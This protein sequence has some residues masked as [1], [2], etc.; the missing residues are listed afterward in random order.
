MCC[1]AM[2]VSTL[3]TVV[4]PATLADVDTVATTVTAAFANDPA[5]SFIVGPGNDAARGAFARALLIPRI[6]RGTAW[7][8]DDGAAVAMWDRRPTEGSVDEDDD[9]WWGA[10]RAEVGEDVWARLNA[11]DGA[12]EAVPPTPP[13]W[14]LG[15]LATHPEVQG[16]GLATAVVRPGLAAADAE[17]WDCWLETSTPANKAFYAGRGFTESL[18]VDI[19]GGPPTWWLRRPAPSTSPP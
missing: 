6:H 10:F 8:T 3:R 11:Y 9:A 15:V 14:Y 17:G 2:R 5:W 16:R 12:L 13:Y 19:P 7:V 1:H 4:R 18:A